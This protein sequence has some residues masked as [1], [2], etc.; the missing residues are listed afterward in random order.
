MTRRLILMRHGETFYNATRRMQGQMDTELSE[1]GIKQADQAAEFLAEAGIGRIVSSDLMRAHETAKAV[2]NKVGVEVGV[3]K[4][5]RETHLG[6][7]QGMSHAEVD[8]QHPGARALWRHDA[9]WAPPEGESRLEV[10]ARA[11]A[12]IDELM[13]DYH[14]W[15]DSTV[16]VVAHGGTIAALTS[17]L[18]E[19]APE[20]YPIFSGL[21]NTC[22]AQLTAR[23]RYFQGSPDADGEGDPVI[24][25]ARFTRDNTKDAQWYLDGWNMSVG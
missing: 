7:W 15:D 9:G 11:R 2:A 19:L 12:V 3:D 17:S 16:L 13:A 10:A 14:Q 6:Q 1:V 25:Q 8:S 24:P 23:P 5:L 22:W 4:R 18:L 21:K 20:Q